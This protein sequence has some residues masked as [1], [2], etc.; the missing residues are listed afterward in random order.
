MVSNLGE[1]LFIFCESYKEPFSSNYKINSY[2][3]V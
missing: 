2:Y 3:D 1:V